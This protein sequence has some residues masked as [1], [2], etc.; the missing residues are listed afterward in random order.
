MHLLSITNIFLTCSVN[1][2]IMEFIHE[3]V[4]TEVKH[5]MGRR[6]KYQ[7]ICKNIDKPYNKQL[8]DWWQ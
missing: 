2:S 1:V 3:K 7:A 4:T 6:G 8:Y 5:G